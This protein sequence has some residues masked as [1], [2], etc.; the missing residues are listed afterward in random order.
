MNNPRGRSALRNAYVPWYY[1]RRI[2]EIEAV[3]IERDLAGLPVALVPPQLLS[4]NA[5][6]AETA[7]LTEIKRIVRNIRRDEQEGLVFPLAYDP[8]TG[9]LAYDLKLLTTGG[10]RQFDTSAIITRYDA[11][12]AM[13]LL[14]DFIMLGHDKVGT[15]AL[16]VSKIELF[17]DSVKAWLS[18]IADVFNAYAI[19]RLMRLNGVDETLHPHLRFSA[20]ANIDLGV[21]GDYVSKLTA[22]G[23]LMPDENMGE[24]LRSIAGLP[25]E[26]AEAVE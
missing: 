14:A 3:G 9:N 18:A 13:S 15:Q 25:A 1:Q 20:P 2:A 6:S 26:E 8:D 17:L 22:A 4:D 10:R 19:P 16:S 23:A 5:T 11:R 21:L 24:Y 7:A 12:I